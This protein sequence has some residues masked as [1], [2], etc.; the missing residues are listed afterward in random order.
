[1]IGATLTRATQIIKARYCVALE[2]LNATP[3]QILVMQ[4]IRSA[5]TKP[6]QAD[7]VA[8]TGIDRSTLADIVK[9]TV[10]CGWVTRTRVKSDSRTYEVKL[11]SSGSKIVTKAD[12]AIAKVDA[13]ILDDHMIGPAVD[14]MHAFAARHA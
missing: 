4:A 9:R 2:P 12:R 6:S 8:V 13:S 1:M 11:T 3:R 7:L 5:S 10:E 14:A